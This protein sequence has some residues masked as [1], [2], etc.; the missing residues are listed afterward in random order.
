MSCPGLVGTLLVGLSH[1]YAAVVRQS[2]EDKMLNIGIRLV[3][4]AVERALKFVFGVESAGN[5]RKFYHVGKSKMVMLKGQ[6]LVVNFNIGHGNGTLRV[7]RKHLLDG[8]LAQRG[9]VGLTQNPVHAGGKVGRIARR[10]HVTITL[11]VNHF[12]DS[13][14]LKA[15]TGPPRMAI[16]VSAFTS[17]CSATIRSMASMKNF[18]PLRSCVTRCE[19]KRMMRLS[20]GNML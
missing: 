9:V 7:G 10:C 20:S 5:D 19:T 18:M 3:K 4:H 11:M 6:G 17:G 15:H 1:F 16:T 2:V 14:N 13:A 12:G 8:P